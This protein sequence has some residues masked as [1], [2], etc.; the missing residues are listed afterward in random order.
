ME[1]LPTNGLR[2]QGTPSSESA[3][4]PPSLRGE[5]GHR[6]LLSAADKV[7][8]QSSL[9]AADKVRMQSLLSAA[10]KIRIQSL[11]ITSQYVA[12][13]QPSI[14]AIFAKHHLA[15]LV[16]SIPEPTIFFRLADNT[17]DAE[18]VG[19]DILVWPWGW[20]GRYG[21]S[22][23]LCAAFLG[24]PTA[25]RVAIP[26]GSEALDIVS[27]GKLRAVFL[28]GRRPVAA[29]FLDFCDD[30]ECQQNLLSHVNAI[31]QHKAQVL[32]DE[33]VHYWETIDSQSVVE[34]H[35]TLSDR[36]TLG[37]YRRFDKT[38]SDLCRWL[39]SLH[40]R[41]TYPDT[42]GK[43]V[44]PTILQLLDTLKNPACDVAMT[45]E[46]M[47]RHYDS[48]TRE[49]ACFVRDWIWIDASA[50]AEWEELYYLVG[51]IMAL[52]NSSPSAT[53]FGKRLPWYDFTEHDFRA[54]QLEPREFPASCKPEDYWG[55][56][57]HDAINYGWGCV[58][59]G[60]DFP[61]DPQL[62]IKSVSA[63]PMADD[64]GAVS[65]SADALFEEAV[66][67]KRG[68][69]PHNAH[70]QLKFGPFAYVEVTELDPNVIFV[71]RAADGTFWKVCTEPKRNYCSFQLPGEQKD[72]VS[73]ELKERV[74][75]GVKL[76]F[77]AIVRDF[78]VVE[79]RETVF[80]SSQLDERGHARIAPGDTPRV[81]YIPRIKYSPCADVEKCV[82]ELSHPERR[83]HFVRG[84]VRK[85]G[86]ASDYQLILAQR[87]GVDVPTGYT[88]VRPHERGKG[89]RDVIYRSRSALQCLYTVATESSQSGPSQWFQ[90]ERD[91]YKLMDALG[92]AVE[93]I[94]ASRHGDGGIDVYATKGR[95]LDEMNWVI[96]CKCWHPKRKIPPN[97]IRELVGV[98]A[99]YPHGTRGMV[100]TTSSFSSGAIETAT[101]ANIRLIDGGEF[102]EL[103]KSV[104]G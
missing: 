80:S 54:L 59:S 91:V 69:I 46:Y 2:K 65:A 18:I 99:G 13:L 103:V 66:A 17:P 42:D 12:S 104:S 10:D 64:P 58:L 83:A 22:L 6:A 63:L 19:R 34:K 27:E 25:C 35:L 55:R 16:A 60:H 1:P 28:R 67:N 62:L 48:D 79:N 86:L 70:V 71:C 72:G 89:K 96:Q 100:I 93:H 101:E 92:F 85:A 33:T 8:I 90:F 94:A 102:M 41:Q 82:K 81:V 47:R 76:L 24:T 61:I 40:K 15:G 45:L 7:R 39:R 68:T 56:V 9:S 31:Q 32:A 38:A 5:P 49:L 53:Q 77:A 23:T 51:G 11:P 52:Y 87:Y 3:G 14:D 57:P 97:I 73:Q 43:I 75:A 36:L 50:S 37:W 44:P 29:F 88:F 20:P 74:E 21:A 78:W 30:P 95:D 98:L 26:S 4:K 84:H